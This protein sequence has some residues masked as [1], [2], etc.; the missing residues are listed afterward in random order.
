M[1][2]W[3]VESVLYLF[4]AMGASVLLYLFSLWIRMEQYKKR[5][6]SQ[7]R[8]FSYR[9]PE[10]REKISTHPTF[11]WSV[12]YQNPTQF[13]FVE[14]R[15]DG[16][17]EIAM[18]PWGSWE[19]HPDDRIVLTLNFREKRVSMELVDPENELDGVRST[20]ER[21]LCQTPV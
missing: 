17:V 2:E 14:H 7:L 11:L 20:I 1:P 21:I 5:L 16:V 4:L 13:L 6:L 8:E 19:L 15:E 10:R 9:V 18:A 12:H 3:N